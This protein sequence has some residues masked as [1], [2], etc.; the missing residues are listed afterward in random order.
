MS[1]IPDADLR[2]G[3]EAAQVNLRA[4]AAALLAARADAAAGR[5]SDALLALGQTVL[6]RLR[7]ADDGVNMVVDR[8]EALGGA[9]RV[10]A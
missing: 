9:V 6:V 1:A 10:E 5:H 4:A 7:D 8:L 2:R 3:F